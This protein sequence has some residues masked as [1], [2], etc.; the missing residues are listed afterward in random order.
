MEAVKRAKR[1][2]SPEQKL[3]ILQ[4]IEADIGN[5]LTTMAAIEKQGIAYSVYNKWKKQLAVGVK[6]SLRNG[7][8]SV[9]KEKKRLERE[10]EKLKAIILSQSQIITDLKKETNWD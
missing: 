1:V 7:K 8:A 10:N 3:N 2:F 9:D 6:S 5:G 4:K